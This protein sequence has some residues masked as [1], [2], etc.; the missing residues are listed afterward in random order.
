MKRIL[1]TLITMIAVSCNSQNPFL[2]GWDTPYGIPDF[3]AVKEKHYVPAVEAGIAQQQAE[4]DA[5]IANPDA[6]TFPE[7]CRPERR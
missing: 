4:I 1:I 5:I 2:T 7:P 6:P 3:D